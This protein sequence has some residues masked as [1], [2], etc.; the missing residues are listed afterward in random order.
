VDRVLHA[1]KGEN[2]PRILLEFLIKQTLRI[3]DFEHHSQDHV[4]FSFYGMLGIH[5]A[6][7]NRIPDDSITKLTEL[8]KNGL[9]MED[10]RPFDLPQDAMNFLALL[11][12]GRQARQKRANLFS[13][14]KFRARQLLVEYYDGDGQADTV[15]LGVSE[16]NCSVTWTF[17]KWGQLD[18][19]ADSRVSA[20]RL[21][22]F[23]EEQSEAEGTTAEERDYHMKVLSKTQGFEAGVNGWNAFFLSNPK[24][25]SRQIRTLAVHIGIHPLMLDPLLSRDV[26]CA[27]LRIDFP[28]ADEEVAPVP[29]PSVS[30]IVR[31]ASLAAPSGGAAGAHSEP[32]YGRQTLYGIPPQKL[33]GT[34]AA[35]VYVFLKK[36][37]RTTMHHHPGDELLLVLEG[38]VQVTFHDSGLT[39]DLNGFSFAHYYAEQ[40]HS[41]VNASL[42]A[43]AVLF[44]IRFHQFDVASTRQAMRREL[45]RKLRGKRPERPRRLDPLLWAWIL[46]TAADRSIKHVHTRPNSESQPPEEQVVNVENRF[47]LARLLRHRVQTWEHGIARRPGKR[48]ESAFLKQAAA[49]C[50]PLAAARKELQEFAELPDFLWAL[51][52]NQIN[53]PKDF[54]PAIVEFFGLFDLHVCEFLFPGVPRHVVVTRDRAH[55][56]VDMAPI[57]RR[58]PELLVAPSA[59]RGAALVADGLVGYEVPSRSLACSDVAV[60][61]LHLESGRA[62]VQNSHEGGELLLPIEGSASI[63]FDDAPAAALEVRAGQGV[64]H[65]HSRRSHRIRNSGPTRATLFLVRFYG[66]PE[67]PAET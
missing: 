27:C 18:Q 58:I 56:W 33:A 6:R 2:T 13:T 54:L 65:F 44:V 12:K 59:Q 26:G 1:I 7:R 15:R 4:A 20:Q 35:F 14:Q 25:S 41:V 43:D 11:E 63:V 5:L 52:S 37:G 32:F 49:T 62:T 10:V 66:D 53:V 48:A 57:V 50:L 21:K 39:V 51:E 38:S 24:L 42:T 8:V 61:I 46:A 16:Q 22:K 3:P 36:G 30:S 31:F 60:S 17:F 47:G 28:T 34:D 67:E 55:D 64:V 45:W 23:L 9:T 19:D 29:E 40:N